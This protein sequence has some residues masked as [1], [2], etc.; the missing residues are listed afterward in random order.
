M[1]KRKIISI[2]FMN[3]NG[4]QK[5]KV[6]NRIIE[7][8]EVLQV[9]DKCKSRNEIKKG[10][11]IKRGDYINYIYDLDV[12]GNDI[13]KYSYTIKVKKNE[14]NIYYETI[15]YLETLCDLTVTLKKVNIARLTAGIIAGMFVLVNAGPHIIKG[16]ERRNEA[17]NQY[18]NEQ[19]Q[20]IQNNINSDQIYYPTEEEKQEAE[21]WYYENI[22]KNLDTETKGRIR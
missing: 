22:E 1:E 11:I 6:E 9:L 5:A 4:K 10:K 18:Q 12:Y 2:N 15:K 20:E 7:I 3:E 16:L 13:K 17:K 21:N 19:Y 8:K 14:K